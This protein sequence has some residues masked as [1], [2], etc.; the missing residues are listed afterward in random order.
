[1]AAGLTS[2]NIFTSPFQAKLLAYHVKMT[3]AEGSFSDSITILNAYQT[4]AGYKNSEYFKR[5]GESEDAREK[6]WARN[7]YIQLKALKVSGLF[8]FFT[9]VFSI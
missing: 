1:M 2:K 8:S 6:M 5:S 3:W 4:W 9:D 7:S